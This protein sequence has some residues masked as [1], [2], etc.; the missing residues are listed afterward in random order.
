M[1]RISQ[2]KRLLNATLL[3]AP[4]PLLLSHHTLSPLPQRPEVTSVAP[5]LP[6]SLL[7]TASLACPPL[8]ALLS[9][10]PNLHLPMPLNPCVPLTPTRC[11]PKPLLS[12]LRPPLRR[13]RPPAAP[14]RAYHLAPNRAFLGPL[15]LVSITLT[16][17]DFPELSPFQRVLWQPC[18][19]L[20]HPH[21]PQ[22]RAGWP[23]PG[24]SSTPDPKAS[25][26]Q[27]DPV[28]PR[29]T[30]LATLVPPG[31]SP[32]L[33]RVHLASPPRAPQRMGEPRPGA[34]LSWPQSS[35]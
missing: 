22:V 27:T 6:T 20:P 17:P 26:P 1:P 18:P 11:H 9:L 3:P 13:I 21:L 4:N 8:F 5:F 30:S 7:A 33:L 14:P 15:L 35:R 31:L 32:P 12:S 29:A 23:R 16:L 10:S 2:G 34:P 28:F 19:L 24:R 25:P